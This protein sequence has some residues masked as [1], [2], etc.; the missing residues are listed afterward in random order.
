MF[1]RENIPHVA[2]G[3]WII[4]RFCFRVWHGSFSD[5]VRSVR[6]AWASPPL[7]SAHLRSVVWWVSTPKRKPPARTDQ[8]TASPATWTRM[9]PCCSHWRGGT[10]LSQKALKKKSGI[11][12]GLSYSLLSVAKRIE[13]V[14]HAEFVIFEWFYCTN[15]FRNL[16]FL[17]NFL[18]DSYP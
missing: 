14:L 4:C 1:A 6:G 10:E 16:F 8:C 2:K 7:F 18:V 3:I 11:E 15:T 5:W 12:W 17:N 13:F 9:M